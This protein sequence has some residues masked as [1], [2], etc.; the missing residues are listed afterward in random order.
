[1]SSLSGWCDD[2]AAAAVVVTVFV[3][4]LAIAGDDG[5]LSW[6]CSAPVG[7]SGDE[8]GTGEAWG[9]FCGGEVIT[10]GWYRLFM[11]TVPV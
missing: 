3:V 7:P 5:W 9:W 4:E 10:R 2:V 8:C 11:V 6:R 1:M